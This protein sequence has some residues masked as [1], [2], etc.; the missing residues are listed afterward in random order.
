MMKI[1]NVEK[2]PPPNFQAP[3][4]ARIPRI[5]PFKFVP[6]PL[7]SRCLQSPNAGARRVPTA[8]AISSCPIP[9]ASSVSVLRQPAQQ[10]EDVVEAVFTHGPAQFGAELGI[11]RVDAVDGRV[12]GAH[13]SDQ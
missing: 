6:S 2:H 8:S 12:R 3:S 11:L 4:P 9:H 5:G 1:S 7:C 13:V 10:P